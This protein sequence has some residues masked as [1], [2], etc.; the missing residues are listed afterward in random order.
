MFPMSRFH[1]YDRDNFAPIVGFNNDEV[2]CPYFQVVIT[3]L[4]FGPLDGNT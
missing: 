3:N 4:P 2:C 1:H